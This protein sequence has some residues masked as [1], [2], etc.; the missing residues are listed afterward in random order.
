MKYFSIALFVIFGCTQKTNDEDIIIINTEQLGGGTED[1]AKG[2]FVLNSLA[3]KVF[4]IDLWYSDENKK[5]DDELIN[6]LK[7]C[8][9]LVIR[10]EI[11]GYADRLEEYPRFKL[12]TLPKFIPLAKTGFATLIEED[13]AFFTVKKF[14]SWEKVNGKMEY[15]FGVQMAMLFDS[16][17]A[18]DFVKKHPKINDV[19]F[20]NGK[21]FKTFEINDVINGRVKKE[22]IE[23]KIVLLG[24]FGPG[25]TDRFYSG[26]IKRGNGSFVP[27]MYSVEFHAH[28]ALQVLS[29]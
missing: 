9:N 25:F 8:K 17:K 23:G 12:G 3:P 24:F 14:S 11:D 21:K 5:V 26:A 20:H 27:D 10:S 19:N 28:V 22:D 4:A 1:L 13:D 2:I 18:A 15:E 29:E 16:I 6:I 7:E